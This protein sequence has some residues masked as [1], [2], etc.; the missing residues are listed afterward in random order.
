M[1]AIGRGRW[2]GRTPLRAGLARCWEF[3]EDLLTI[4]ENRWQSLVENRREFALAYE[5]VEAALSRQ[6]REEGG[7]DT[8]MELLLRQVRLSKTKTKTQTK[9]NTKSS[10]GGG[11]TGMELLLR[12]NKW[13]TLII[14]L[15]Q[16][17]IDHDQHWR[18]PVGQSAV[19]P[20]EEFFMMRSKEKKLYFI[21]L[22]QW[23]NIYCSQPSGYQRP[24]H[25]GK[26]EEWAEVC[27]GE[28][29]RPTHYNNQLSQCI[30]IV[31]KLLIIIF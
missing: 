4:F 24:R 14:F 1:V 30:P 7:V 8:G 11:D 19:L 28:R 17:Q 25:R 18:S 21:Y 6:R 5:W 20:N 23:H 9:T 15:R 27:E 22:H 3:C 13:K 26:M 16:I 12:Q 2:E 31:F 10:E 29:S